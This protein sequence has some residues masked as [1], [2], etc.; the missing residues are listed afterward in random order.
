MIEEIARQIGRDGAVLALEVG[1][2]GAVFGFSIGAAA[3]TLVAGAGSLLHLSDIQ[4][5]ERSKIK[6]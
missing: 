4:T 5:V 3:S 6:C 1:I 2:A